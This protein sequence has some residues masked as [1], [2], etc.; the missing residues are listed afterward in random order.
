MHVVQEPTKSNSNSQ[1][2]ACGV[3]VIV[4][5]HGGLSSNGAWLAKVMQTVD[6]PACGTLPDFGNFNL[7][8]DK[9]Y[10]R[11]Q[12]VSELMPYARAVSAK[13]HE[14]DEEGNEKHTDY[15]RMMQIVADA[16]YHGYVGIEYEG[17]QLSE[18]E[19]IIATKKLLERVR[20]RLGHRGQLETALP[21]RRA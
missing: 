8:G 20:R 10:D 11:Y 3:W 9:W 12:G 18:M 16:G 4:E 19:G 17:S 6:H 2:T 15:L 7:G 13:S 14:F 1:P 5:N 21:R